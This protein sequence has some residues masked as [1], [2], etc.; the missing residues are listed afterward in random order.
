VPLV[1][2]LLSDAAVEE[3]VH[4]A[5]RDV[6]CS[7]VVVIIP[8]ATRTA[9]VPLFFKALAEGL[10][11]RV[12]RLTFLVALGTHPLMS[13]EALSKLVGM[14][15]P[16]R[17]ELFPYVEVVN[18]RWDL[19]ETFETVGELSEQETRE[20]SEGRLSLSVP[21][22]VNK[23]LRQADKV[24][25]VGPVFPHEVAGFSGGGKYLFPGVGGADVINFT[26]WLGA[27]MTSHATIGVR[28][29]AVR[30]AIELAAS[31]VGGDPSAFC[32][33]T[34]KEG[35]HGMF[36]GEVKSAWRQATELSSEIH[37][38]WCEKPYQRVL[39]MIPERYDDLWTGAKGMYKV[40][41]VLADGGEVVLLAPHITEFSY[42]HGK[43][44]DQ[45]GYHV[46]D[47]FLARWDQFKE[48]PWGVLAHS[49][50]LRGDGTYIE[51]VEKPRIKVTL[52]SA[53]S[54]QRCKAMN[55]GYLDPASVQIDDWTDRE[56]EGILLV[57]N[58]GETL[59]RLR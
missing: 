26:H 2:K 10:R 11:G 20:L 54:P 9:P 58:A 59:Y 57:P 28:E 33:V 49:T 30:R 21:I 36:W 17:Q 4:E 45:I 8:D 12:D 51:G 15:L 3:R 55:L 39:S 6:R 41:P 35:L 24:I 22:R 23:I 14:T 40:E 46:R 27:L 53:I 50:H 13:T 16:E 19:P 25:I 43:V 29:T 7:H 31:R 1:P 37:I 18:H 48:L 52:A 42:T 38:K 5:I 32:L 44:L 34:S 47:Y 56:D